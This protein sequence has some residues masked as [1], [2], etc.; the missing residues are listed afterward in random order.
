MRATFPVAVHLFLL[1]DDKV[2]LLERANTGYED[3]NWG[4]VAGHLEAGE[5]VTR[6]A[7]REAREEVAIAL[8]PDDLEVVGVMHR[9]SNDERVDFFFVARRWAGTPVNAEP[10]KCAGL[11]W[12]PLDALPAN[13]VAYIR[14]ALSNFR[15]G[16]WFE[17]HGWG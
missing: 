11:A 15:R 9:K 13:T 2:L 6:C 12:C 10:G 8:A 3:G 14:D 4:V 5:S 7:I 17:E 16:I 1:E